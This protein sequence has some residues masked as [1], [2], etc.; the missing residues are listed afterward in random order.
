M[1]DSN[2][3]V[4]FGADIVQALVGGTK[5][6]TGFDYETYAIDGTN[7]RTENNFTIH[8]TN[9]LPPKGGTGTDAW[10]NVART[11]VLGPCNVP[12]SFN[13]QSV[14]RTGTG[15][16]DVVFTTPMPTANY[17]VVGSSNSTPGSTFPRSFIADNRTTAGFTV[18][19][20]GSNAAADE[21]F[22]FTVNAANATLPATFTS[23]QIQSVLDF[24]A[25]ANPAGVARAWGHIEANGTLASG[26][27]VASVTKTNTGVYVVAFITPM[28][29]ANYSLVFGGPGFQQVSA[30]TAS[31]FTL[32]VAGTGSNF[33][34][35]NSFSVYS[36]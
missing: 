23:A 18:N 32:A 25:V 5:T 3:A 4:T 2:Y 13:T 12:A 11:T 16:Y 8:A 28:P 36:S 9:A 35:E 24:I 19:I 20:I 6:A 31:G 33:D 14:T 27:N 17:S 22:S 7:T 21:G 1:P 26:F 34:S 29:N 30:K 10:G 15:V